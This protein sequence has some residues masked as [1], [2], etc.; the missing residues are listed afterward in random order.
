MTKPYPEP[1]PP[2][3][4][5]YGDGSYKIFGME[6]FG[7]TCYCN[8]ILQCLYYTENFRKNLVSHKFTKHEPKLKISGSKLHS[9]SNKYEQ[10]LQKKLKEQGKV[11]TQTPIS[12]GS[13]VSGSG[14]LEERPKS[15]RKGSLFGIKF[16][17]SS[18]TTTAANVIDSKTASYIRE[19]KDW[20]VL[21]LEQ[22]L[23][24]KKCAEFQK[25]PILMTRPTNH[26]V[27]PSGRVDYSQS[28]SMLLNGDQPQ[29]TQSEG[30]ISST[31]SAIIVG[32]PHPE[33]NLLV[34]I[35][36][37]NV[38]PGADQRKRSALINGPIINLDASLQIGEQHE[39]SILMYALKDIFESMI[40]NK[41]TIGVVSPNYFIQK[42][43]DRNYLFR[44]NN[45][46]HDAHEFFN[47][48]IN[49]IIETLNRE[50]GPENNWCNN[51][52]R[53]SITNETKCLSCETVSS[54]HEYF[55]DLS[56]DIP[57]GES[58]YSLSYSLN[59]FSKS[60]TL[61]NQNKFYCNTCSSLQEAVKTI[62]LNKLPEVLVI[63]F[64]RFKYDETVDKMVKLFD[65]I[66]YPFKLKLFNTTDDDQ[67]QHLYELYALVVHIGGGPMHGHYVSICKTK[68]GLWLLFDDETVELVDDS[69]VM[70]FFG[71]GPGLASAYILFYSKC[72]ETSDDVVDFG[73][74]ISSIYKGDDFGLLQQVNNNS[75]LSLKKPTT[76]EEVEQ[77]KSETSSVN[78]YNA[79]EAK[80]Q[81]VFKPF[82]FDGTKEEKP[83]SRSSSNKEPKEKKSWGL[84]WKN[85]SDTTNS[86]KKASVSGAS[87]SVPERKK[88]IFGFKRK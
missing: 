49:E 71:N 17:N 13:V 84:K 3:I 68:Y 53:G 66:S 19:A 31:S 27:N 64:K 40:E 5:P 10:L 56:I 46:H 63:N 14:G 44:Q 8:S 7:N 26:E 33:T 32:I 59:N 1:N 77:E 30:S 74:D 9:F 35:N 25:L 75:D 78:S 70:R 43:K 79:P 47:Y 41:S 57:P 82:K 39:D 65:S 72:H 16:N 52:F 36:P 48:L 88:S 18:S 23:N 6:N 87:S 80:K 51:I 12:A 4:L 24:I 11:P 15:S 86:D 58:A 81:G 34:P 42:L 28:S 61:T 69:Y 37:F 2:V 85:S 73:F 62:K 29:Q 45:M 54:R 22:R 60:E 76:A 21:T 20:D 55:L 83:L 38:N 50:V 67:E